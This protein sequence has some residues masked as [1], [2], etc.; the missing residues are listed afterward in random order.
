MTREEELNNLYLNSMSAMEFNF[1]ALICPYNIYQ[2]LSV[3]DIG[4][5]N[6]I[7]TSVKYMGSVSKR[8]IMIDQI[9]RRRNFMKFHAGTN[10]V[11]YK[12]LDDQSFVAKFPIDSNGIFDNLAEWEVQGFLK[13][14]NAKMFQRTDCGTVSFSELVKPIE[15]R[16]EFISIADS[17]FDLLYKKILGKFIMDDIGAS[18][19][20][21]YGLRQGFGPVFLDFPRVFRLDGGKLNCNADLGGVICNGEIDYD[22]T[23]DFIQC[24]CCG[25]KYRARDLAA[26]IEN[27]MIIFEKG[28]NDMRI[29]MYGPDGQ[30]RY[31]SSD[32]VESDV[33]V[34]KQDFMRIK[35]NRGV[36]GEPKFEDDEPTIVGP[37]IIR[38]KAPA[39][40][41]KLP[42]VDL[43]LNSIEMDLKLP[44][45]DK[46]E[47][48]EGEPLSEEFITNDEPEKLEPEINYD[49]ETIETTDDSE[50]ESHEDV[51]RDIVDD[52]I[53]L[54]AE[55]DSVKSDE[56][57]RYETVY[58]DDAKYETVYSDELSEKINLSPLPEGIRDSIAKKEKLVIESRKKGSRRVHQD[59]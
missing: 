50:E 57:P 46:P 34:D 13:P 36:S 19:F 59:F 1:D 5:I 31:S 2:L 17:V 28:V 45:H 24:S 21:N 26:E 53:K 51:V 9:L 25:K 43:K 3:T 44:H 14:F 35:M 30:V 37:D 42:K 52:A 40:K 41:L 22:F 58:S 33:V 6:T 16:E 4:D 55:M 29:K 56:E 11:V 10:R 48:Q 38:T 8:K 47:V 7:A 39:M 27:K 15:H 32:T 54:K 49:V 12:F 18:K 20:M 23:F